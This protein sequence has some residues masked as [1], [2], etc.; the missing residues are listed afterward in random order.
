MPTIGSGITVG[1]G[2]S[3]TTTPALQTTNLAVYLDATNS[4]SYSGS[5]TTWTDLSG[6]GRNYTWLSTPSF[7]ASGTSSYFSTL[8]N[9]CRGP[10]SNSFGID[11]TSGYTVFLVMMQNSLASTAAFKWY[12]SNGAGAQ[13]RGIFSH[14]TWSDGNVYFD[15]GGCCGPD[16]RVFSSAFGTSTF[17][18]YTFRRATAGSTRTIF[19]NG[20]ILNSEAAAAA[21]INLTS[22]PM[23]LASSDEY[24]GNT[25]TW[26]ARLGAF[27][28]YNAGLTDAQVMSVYQS[29]K[30]KWGLQ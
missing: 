22:T 2:V 10:A 9:C 7:T 4:S 20:I 5:G 19:K 25:S 16:T 8:G 29:L 18:V 3:V 13:S 26:D 24:G 30:P 15:Q 12:S 1:P 6:N 11:N 28:V 21:N 17:A 27:L 14:C 23:D